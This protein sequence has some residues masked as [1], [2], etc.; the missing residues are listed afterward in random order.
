[1]ATAPRD[2]EDEG[3]RGAARLTVLL[4]SHGYSDAAITLWWNEV[5]HPELDNRTA[6][7]AWLTGRQEDREAMT[8]L[9]ETVSVEDQKWVATM[10]AAVENGSLKD[11]IAAQ[12]EPRAII[13]GWRTR[14]GP[15]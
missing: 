15:S 9:V 8:R 3:D 13:D 11:R 6:S 1:M 5:A 2:L 14:L 4:K 12:L 7:Q 10:R